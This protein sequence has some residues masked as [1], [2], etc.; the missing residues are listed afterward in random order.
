MTGVATPWR[1]PSSTISPLSQS[2]SVEVEP[3]ASDCHVDPPPRGRPVDR[4]DLHHAVAP[5]PILD[6]GRGVDAGGGEARVGLGPRPRVDL[7]RVVPGDHERVERVG[8]VHQQLA[9]LEPHDLVAGPARQAARLE[10]GGQRLGVGVEPR[11]IAPDVEDRVVRLTAGVDDARLEE[12][13]R[14][15]HADPVHV[16]EQAEC[17]PLVL[18]PV[19]GAGDGDPGRGVGPQGVERAGRVLRLH[20]QDDDVARLERARRRCGRRRAPPG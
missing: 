18:H 13:G 7:R 5:G 8:E 16:L 15:H 3:R 6:V 20:R 12:R 14:Q 11:R 1:R 19:L 2:T 4:R 17:E 9:V 10:G